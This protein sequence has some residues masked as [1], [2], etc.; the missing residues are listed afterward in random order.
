[1][2]KTDFFFC[3]VT[4]DFYWLIR[5]SAEG[6]PMKRCPF[7]ETNFEIRGVG[8]GGHGA[9]IAIQIFQESQM[10]GGRLTVGSIGRFGLSQLTNQN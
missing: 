6:P 10:L 1:M 4:L 7:K 8:Q 9:R 5:L 2:S 3:D